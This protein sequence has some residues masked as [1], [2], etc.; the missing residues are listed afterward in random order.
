MK[1]FA[2]KFQVIPR[3]GVMVSK[4][5]SHWKPL[6]EEWCKIHEQYC[7]LVP[8]DAVFVHHELSDVGA[9]AAAAWRVPEWAAL[10]EWR[11]DKEG[12]EFGRTDLYLKSPK[13]K[14]YIEAKSVFAFEHPTLRPRRPG[15]R[16]SQPQ[17][18]RPADLCQKLNQACTEAQTIRIE[19]DEPGQRIGLVFAAANI[20]YPEDIDR[21]TVNECYLGLLGHAV[22]SCDD[23][24]VAWCFPL[25][26]DPVESA[27]PSIA[28]PGVLLLARRIRD[29]VTE[30]T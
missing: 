30:R 13:S 22:E 29:Q 18:C 25:L 20:P 5:L 10:Q 23:D 2:K 9:L 7:R 24:A 14:E 28:F 26:D 16:R 11:S 17:P 21:T 3:R 6:L 27:D 1:G 4:K 19:D 12:R 8:G 15:S